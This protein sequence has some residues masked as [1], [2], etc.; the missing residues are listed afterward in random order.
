MKAPDALLSE[1]RSIFPDSRIKSRLIDRV[2]Y[3]SDAGFYHL[4]PRVVVQPADPAEVRELFALCQRLGIPLVFRAGGS[5]LSG[6]AITDGVLADLSRHWRQATP[7]PDGSSI[8]V[9][10][11]ITGAMVNQRLKPFRTKIG[12]D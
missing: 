1:L 9:Q 4:L 6:Q 11:G 5:S 8:K 3:A 12:P 7:A 10:P 2:A